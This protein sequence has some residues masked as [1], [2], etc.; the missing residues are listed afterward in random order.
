MKRV[1]GFTLIELM[2]VVAV[3]AILAGIAITQYSKQVR[4]G[5]RA[6]AKQAI[7]TLAMAEEKYRMNNPLYATCDQAFA[8]STCTSYNGSLNAYTV[9]IS[10]TPTGTAY[11]IT[12]T[13]KTADQLKDACGTFTY[14][15][16]NGVATKTPTTTGCWR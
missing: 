5:R 4:K 16:S 7:A 9:A 1:R 13:P 12:A 15:V 6:E 3:V 11:T 8:P 10:G 14:A 2:I